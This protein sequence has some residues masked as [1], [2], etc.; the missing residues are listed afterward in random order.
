M[1]KSVKRYYEKR[2]KSYEDLD[3][4]RTI[5]SCVRAIGIKDHLELME[6]KK[7]ELILDVGCGNGRFLSPFN[8]IARAFGV[9]F[10]VEM[11]KRADETGSPLVRADA[12]HLPYKEGAFDKV[13]SAG[14]LGVFNSSRV[15]EEMMRVTKKRGKVFIS[16]PAATSISG[17]VAIPFKKLGWNPTLLDYWYSKKEIDS[18]FP[19]NARVKNYF[20]LGFEPPFQRLLKNLKSPTLVKGFMFFERNLRDKPFFRFFGGRYFVEVEK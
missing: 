8:K 13:H 5:V 12:E 9:D 10:T 20:R 3:M 14:L 18:M 2:A 16:F 19:P 4:P 6:I 15:C 7:G 1:K 17:I 11:L